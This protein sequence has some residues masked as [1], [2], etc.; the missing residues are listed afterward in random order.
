[1]IDDSE[2]HNLAEALLPATLAAGRKIMSH[3]R[4]DLV[5]EHKRD[6]SPVTRADREA[7]DILVAALDRAAPH[8]PVVAE[9]RMSTGQIPVVEND[10]FLVDALD[11]T[12]GFIKGR[13]DFTVNIG[14]AA[15]SR[16]RFGIVYAPALSQLYMTVGP[17][18]AIQAEISPN[19]SVSTISDLNARPLATRPLNRGDLTAV[20]SRNVAKS[21]SE[22]LKLLRATRLDRSSSIKFCV[23]ARGDADI[24]PRFGA[25]S[26][27]DT[28]AGAAIVQAAGGCVT[29]IDGTPSH[30]GKAEHGFKNDAFVAWSTPEP[31]PTILSILASGQV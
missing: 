27:W 6:E 3:Y 10:L 22:R 29:G 21:L 16:S 25:I 9:E 11:G 24:Y 31:D 30:Y 26:E 15:N 14:Y 2:F 19:V 23:V 8:V 18:A 13:T 28:A 4:S 12:R 7:E 1:M 5:V 20:S 17:N